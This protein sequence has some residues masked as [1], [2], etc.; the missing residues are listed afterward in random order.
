M[1]LMSCIPFLNATR[2]PPAM[3]WEIAAGACPEARRLITLRSRE[4]MEVGTGTSA[5]SRRCWMH[6]PVGPAAEALGKD[7]RIGSTL[8]SWRGQWKRWVSRRYWGRTLGVFG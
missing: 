3:Y 7:R 6:R 8:K 4:Q 1:G 5:T 2:L